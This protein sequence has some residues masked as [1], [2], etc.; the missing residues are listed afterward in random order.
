MRVSF[1]LHAARGLSALHKQ[2]MIHRD[3]KSRNLLVHFDGHRYVVK[4]CD[5][6]SARLIAEDQNNRFS[7]S[8]SSGGY[9]QSKKN[10]RSGTSPPSQEGEGKRLN[11]VRSIFRTICCATSD[12]SRHHVGMNG[13]RHEASDERYMTYM[14]AVVGT[15]AYM[16]PELMPPDFP[17][18]SES[19][20]HASYGLSADIFS[21]GYVIWELLTR[22]L[23][24]YALKDVRTLLRSVLRGGRPPVPLCP[25]HYREIMLE[26]WHQD[27][28]K[29]P[30]IDKLVRHLEMA[31]EQALKM[32]F[33]CLDAN[34]ASF[35]GVAFPWD[36]HHRTPPLHR[37][38]HSMYQR[39][40]MSPA[41]RGFGLPRN[42][43]DLA[44]EA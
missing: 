30:T 9:Y 21:F 8:S 42:V 37:L 12:H 31:H 29:R 43:Q 41:A 25:S 39:G 44:R 36:K 19:V 20:E 4:L 22:R 5:F 35:E 32:D 13:R 28:S 33:E 7:S 3:I 11:C 27:P 16:A 34:S 15:L 1:A 17:F 6:G 14:T 24:Y 26:C 23:P 10:S 40:L 38:D 2:N 18:T